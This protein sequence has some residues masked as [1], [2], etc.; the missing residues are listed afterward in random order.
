MTMTQVYDSRR[1]QRL[2]EL[3]EMQCVDNALPGVAGVLLSDQISACVAAF[4]MIVPFDAERLRPAGYELSIGDEISIGGKRKVLKDAPGENTFVLQPFNVAVMKIHETLNLPRNII[5]RWNI[6]VSLAYDGLVW[7]G[8]PQVDPGWV[9]NLSCPIYNLGSTP[10]TLRLHQPIAVIDFV[11]T[12]P[13]SPRTCKRFDRPPKRVVFD[14]YWPEKLESALVTEAKTRIDAFDA[15]LREEESRLSSF[16]NYTYVFIGIIVAALSILVTSNSSPSKV[17]PVWTYVNS[18][19]AIVALAFAWAAFY[20]KRGAQTPSARERW[21]WRFVCF[22][23][24]VA[25]WP[26][27]SPLLDWVRGR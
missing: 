2:Q 3:K 14:D 4:Q 19:L 15:K 27:L 5:G 17:V 23:L 22:V 24:G 16:V 18:V 25:S 21:L 11:T 26:V 6:K 7:V 10:L 8:G 1:E 13:F 12:T 9:G 20:R